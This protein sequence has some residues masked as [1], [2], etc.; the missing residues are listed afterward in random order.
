MYEKIEIQTENK[1]SQLV[2]GQNIVIIPEFTLCSGHTLYKVPV[3]YKTWGALNDNKDNVMVI[4]HALSGSSDV[5][6]WGGPLIGKGRAFDPTKFF[7]FCGNVLGSPYG[8]ASPVTINPETGKYYGPEFPLTTPQDDVRL[9]KLILDSLGINQV[10]ICIG[11]SMGGMQILEWSFFGPE[12]VK[13]LVPIA[14]S[15]RNSAWCI[16]WNEAQR[17][18]IYSDIKYRDGYY[19]QN[20]PPASGLSA[21]RMSALLTYRSRDSFESRFGR[22]FQDPKK[23]P[24]VSNSQKKTSLSPAEKALLIHNDGHKSENF[25]ITNNNNK[26]T[27]AENNDNEHSTKSVPHVF[28]AQSYLRY[29]GD[30]FVNRFDANCYINLTRKMDSHDIGKDRGKL[31]D[32]LNSIQQQT[33]VIGIESDGLFTISEQYKLAEFIPNSEM[34][35]IQ[36]PDGHDGFLLEFDQINRHLVRFI[37]KFLPEISE[38]ELCNIKDVEG[39]EGDKQDDDG[40][41]K[42]TKESL[43]GEAEVVKW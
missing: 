14:T 30:K 27:D 33:L 12:Y 26:T 17:Q 16:S 40:K 29:Q 31:E 34:V 28:S 20:D 10:A 3:A 39:F 23:H 2:H 38:K 5:Q 42:A 8:T 18:S 19:D 1:F 9:H 6:D 24:T 13:T 7:I 36:S 22:K 25:S 43:F 41:I 37:N 11:G 21:A 32:V 15:A 35:T 4:C